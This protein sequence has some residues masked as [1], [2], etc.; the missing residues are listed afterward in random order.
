MKR[1]STFDPP[2]YVNWRP[3]PLLVEAYA[4][5]LAGDPERR[6]RV[7]ELGRDDLLEIYAHLLR[8]RLVDTGLKR[9]VRQGVISKAWL[10]TGEE[11]VTVGS[12]LALDR[13]RDVVSPMIRNA[14]AGPL[15]GM[16]LASTFRGYLATK[17]APNG[18]RDLH[19]GD[20]SLGVIQPISH[21]GTNVPVMVGVALASRYLGEG[22]VALTWIGDGASKCGEC[23]EGLTLAVQQRLPVVFILQNNQVAL[24]TRAIH[25]GA[26]ELD[27]WPQL[28]GM[29]GW[30]ADGN[31]VLDMYAATT[32]AVELCR[33]GEG[34]A[35]VVA[36][37]F[38]MGGHATHDEREAR[39]AFPASLFE[40]WGKRDPIGLY[41][42]WLQG[43]GVRP[44][45][46]EAVEVAVTAE[47]EAAAAEALESRGRNPEPDS[48]LYPG[49]SEG[50]TLRSLEL[51]PVKVL[52]MLDSV[53]HS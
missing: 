23:H 52:Q 18:G 43:R 42:V 31:H 50:G 34:P 16:S 17:D 22:R 11:A 8:T 19:I 5:R 10:G 33:R 24:G 32:L 29:R 4:S 15:M 45:E 3:D 27:H 41:E 36:H 47:V 2:E 1:S 14:G 49:I 12:V 28:Y 35:M 40:E 9:W 26:G 7:A 25:H 48:A 53:R 13:S 51:R 21:M 20:P 37:T 38:R 44:E 39:E 6:G 30:T 46:L